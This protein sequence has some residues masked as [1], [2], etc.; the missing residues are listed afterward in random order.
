MHGTLKCLPCKLHA[1]SRAPDLTGNVPIRLSQFQE[2]TAPYSA[3][4][5]SCVHR[6]EHE[7]SARVPCEQEEW[8][9]K[10]VAQGAK[11]TWSALR[12]GAV[13]GWSLVSPIATG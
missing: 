8:A 11:W 3:G 13:I 5:A 4:P 7:A 1:Q 6:A 2:C 9:M 12:P 10:K